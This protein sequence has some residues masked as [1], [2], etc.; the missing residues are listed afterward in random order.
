MYLANLMYTISRF[1]TT[2]YRLSEFPYTSKVQTNTLHY[3]TTNRYHNKIITII[4]PFFNVK[5]YL[6][7]HYILC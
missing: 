5:V 3:W 1:E 7:G 6:I 4:L 2:K